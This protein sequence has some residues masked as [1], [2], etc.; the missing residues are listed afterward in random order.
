[1]IIL[2]LTDVERKEYDHT[3]TCIIFDWDDTLCPST[4]MLKTERTDEIEHELRKLERLVSH[5][6]TLALEYGHVFI[7]TN[8]QQGWVEV[9]VATYMPTLKYWIDKV[10]V[11]SA[12]SRFEPL[13]PNNPIAWKIRAVVESLTDLSPKQILSF[14][15]S[16]VERIAM[17]ET[18]KQKNISCIK[19]IKFIENPTIV[20]LSKQWEVLIP[21][22][23]NIVKKNKNIDMFLTSD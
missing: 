23:S 12:R 1:M 4:F 22:F 6:L 21:I 19:N 15:D 10:T 13:Y 3:E 7:I 5:V 20:Q 16:Y 14:G 17:L 2:D 9:A 8:A 18:A 11:V